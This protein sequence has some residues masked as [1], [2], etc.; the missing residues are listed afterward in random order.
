MAIHRRMFLKLTGVAAVAGGLR[1]AIPPA[2]A[3]AAPGVR[4][5][6]RLYRPDGGRILVSDDGG[7]AWTRHVNLGDENLVTRLAVEG[8]RLLA[9]VEHGGRWFTLALAG[10][11]AAWMTAG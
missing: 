5:D 10:D 1:L 11:G 3:R 2:P 7:R 8:G 4:H 6:G 9:T